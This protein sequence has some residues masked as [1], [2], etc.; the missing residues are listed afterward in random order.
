MKT[1]NLAILGYGSTGRAFGKLLTE[2]VLEIKEK[3]DTDVKVTAIATKTKGTLI[4]EAG[5]D[6]VKIEKELEET[7]KFADGV[8]MSAIEVAE[9]S[10]YD[11]LI[12][13]TP[14][15]IFSGQPATSHI[16]AALSR[17]KHAISANKGPI[18]W[19]FRELRDLAEKNKCLFFY[20]TTVMDGAPIFN[21]ASETLKMCKVTEICGILNS[22]TNFILEEMAKGLPMDDIMEEGKRRGFVEADPTLDTEGWDS[23]AKVTA[24]LNVLMDAGI[25]PKDI[26]RKGIED[27][28]PEMIESAKKRGKVIKL[29]CGGK[30]ENGQATGY[31]RPEEVSGSDLLAGITG[32]TSIVKITTDLMGSVSIVE[33]DPEIEQTAYGVFSDT[34]RVLEKSFTCSSC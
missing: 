14:L 26:N 17:G 24:L 4:C 3:Y 15:E 7:G 6:L 2:K 10:E 1:C 31:V 12:E 22:T 29:L 30:I 8:T 11:V 32:T 9:S 13:L 19:A 21:L 34:L 20:E 5:I 18:A 25:T 28:T 33:H 23:A 16:K 27:I